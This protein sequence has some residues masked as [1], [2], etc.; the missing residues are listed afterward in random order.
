MNPFKLR[1]MLRSK[2]V[3]CPGQSYIVKFDNHA[4]SKYFL[5]VVKVENPFSS[6]GLVHFKCNNIPKIRKAPVWFFVKRCLRLEDKKIIEV[7]IEDG[8]KE[9]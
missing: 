3:V 8:K 6:E 7:R 2:E 9:R 1:K 4:L 5:H